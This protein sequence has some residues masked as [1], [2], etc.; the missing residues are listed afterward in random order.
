MWSTDAVLGVS[1]AVLILEGKEFNAVLTPSPI[2]FA[3]VAF[4]ITFL[5]IASD[6]Q[7]VWLKAL[8]DEANF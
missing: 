4:A 3:E 5:E 2:F 7:R 8:S 6:V 1:T